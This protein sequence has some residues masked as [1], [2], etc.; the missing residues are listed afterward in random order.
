[1]KA[2]QTPVKVRVRLDHTKETLY[3]VL[4]LN[5]K[6]SDVAF[7]LVWRLWYEKNK[8][9]SQIME[10]VLNADL[11]TMQKT[12]AL[13]VLG[14]IIGEDEIKERMHHLLDHMMDPDSVHDHGDDD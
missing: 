7:D 5:R 9:A 1:M 4:G 6:D 13:Y 10:K 2:V 8:Q 3:K 12:F 11:S 14:R